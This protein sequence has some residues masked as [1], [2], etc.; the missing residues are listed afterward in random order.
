M[1]KQFCIFF[2][3]SFIYVLLEGFAEITKQIQSEITSNIS[4]GI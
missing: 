2:N 1:N 4:Q 3:F